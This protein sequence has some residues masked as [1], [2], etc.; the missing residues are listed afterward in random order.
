[1]QSISYYLKH[2]DVLFNIILTK[3]MGW[4][5]DKVFL[6]IKFRNRMGYRLDLDNPKTIN[7][8]LQWLKLYDRRP[9]YT[10]MVDK[11]KVKEYVSSVIGEQF[12][13][14]TLGVW[15]N[16]DKI[17]FDALPDRFVLKCN[18]NSGLGMYI[19]K[20]KSRMNIKEVKENLRKGL[21]QNYYLSGREWPYKE[22]PRRILAE[23]YIDPTP[24]VR[25]LPVYRWYCFNNEPHFCHVLQDQN[26][27]KP[28]VIFNSEETQL[29]SDLS[30][31]DKTKSLLCS[32]QLNTQLHIVRELIKGL[33]Y[34]HVD[35]Y[36]TGNNSFFGEVT[37]YP[38]SC[39]ESFPLEQYQAK[40]KQMHSIPGEKH[41][42][43][44]IREIENNRIELEPLSLQDYKIYCFNGE[45]KMIMVSYGRFTDNM[46]FDYYT[47]DWKKTPMTWGANNSDII[48]KRPVNFDLMLEICRK[49]SVGIPHVRVDL[50]NVQ[51]RIY[52]GEFT[53]FDSS[54]FEHIDPPKWDYQFGEWLTIPN[55]KKNSK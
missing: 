34:S 31:T 10:M 15:D 5:P 6:K 27:S 30:L 8:K 46:T 41:G 53:F 24:N 26:N 7:E 3:Y 21:K 4:L 25:E 43:Y 47:A 32:T 1:M 20:D 54:G 40:F 11:V 19:C 55:N 52:F 35:L 14:P 13:I 48:A 22:V 45:P 39:F 16:P 50:Y 28:I 18:H 23:T 37:S 42:Q 49:L 36:E 2:R 33:E 44:I 29:S 51:G 12:T 9:E 38:I 17:D